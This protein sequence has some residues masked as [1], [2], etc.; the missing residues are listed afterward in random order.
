MKHN[1]ISYILEWFPHICAALWKKISIFTPNNPFC[2]PPTI[3]LS[4]LGTTV[5]CLI[6]DGFRKKSNWS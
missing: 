4:G 2:S 5:T 6:G 3:N 1:K